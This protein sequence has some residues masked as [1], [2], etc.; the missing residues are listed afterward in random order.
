MVLQCA[1]NMYVARVPIQGLHASKDADCVAFVG[2]RPKNLRDEFWDRLVDEGSIKWI[3]C[4]PGNK[5]RVSRSR[6]KS[7]RNGTSLLHHCDTLRRFQSLKEDMALVFYG[8]LL[9]SFVFC[10]SD[11]F[12]VVKNKLYTLFQ[13]ERF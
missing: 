2:C 13:F 4:C 7:L 6:L 10:P 8:F 3:L 5:G 1:I 9:V 11:R 12:T